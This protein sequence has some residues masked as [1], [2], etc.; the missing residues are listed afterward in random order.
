[1]K[2]PFDLPEPVDEQKPGYYRLEVAAH[3]AGAPVRLLPPAPAR[4][5]PLP[6]L[7]DDRLPARRRLHA[8]SCRSTGGPANGPQRG[9]P[10][11]P[12]AR[13]HRPGPR[14]DRRA[15]DAIRVLGP[16][17]RRRAGLRPRRLPAVRRRYRP[18]VPLR[19]LDG[20]RR[21]LGHRPGP[22]GPLGGRDPH[23]GRVAEVL[24]PLLARTPSTCR[25]TWS[26]ASWT[27]A[28][29]PA[30]PATW[31]ATCRTATTPRWS[32][33]WAGAT[34][35]SP[36]SSCGCSTG[37][38][39]STAT[40]SPTSSP[41]RRCGRGTTS[42]GGR[43]SRAAAGEHGR[44]GHLAAAPQHPALADRGLHPAHNNLTLRTGT[45]ET[46][47]WLPPQMVDFQKRMNISVN[48]HRVNLARPFIRPAWKR[49]WKTPAPAATG[50]IRSGPR[51]RSPRAASTASRKGPGCTGRVT[52]P[53]WQPAQ[54][55][56]CG[57]QEVR[58]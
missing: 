6:P 36:T 28:G 22:P 39:A 50:S 8:P 4:V 3:A 40:S 27:A 26:A 25:S 21:G 20:R 57:I 43:R 15:P 37:W 47:V 18:R 24:Q 16:R 34:S 35:T 54:I 29:W 14:L 51:S 17:A 42:S 23:R 46:T 56:C 2:P 58:R 31:T 19:P 48:G 7:P 44:P 38:A 12:R 49:C 53:Y 1:M 32:S 55:R 9:R 13:L 41:A 5:Q 45:K 10:A 11:R 30:T 33:T 52:V